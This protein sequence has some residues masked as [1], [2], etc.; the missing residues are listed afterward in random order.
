MPNNSK[1]KFKKDDLVI[2][3]SKSHPKKSGLYVIESLEH[4]DEKGFDNIKTSNSE[5]YTGW[6]YKLT[7]IDML[8][9][10]TSLS[11]ADS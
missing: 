6:L 4:T 3:T 2:L 5:K 8:V 7:D 10:E 11:M 9:V 1:S